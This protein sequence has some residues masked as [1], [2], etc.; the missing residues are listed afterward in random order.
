MSPGSSIGDE[1][2]AVAASP[3]ASSCIVSG[4]FPVEMLGNAADE[5]ATPDNFALCARKI[6]Q[7]HIRA[8]V[9]KCPKCGSNPAGYLRGKLPYP[10][11]R[12]CIKQA[13][14]AA[15]AATANRFGLIIII[16]VPMTAVAPVPVSVRI[17]VVII[18]AIV[19]WIIVMLII[20]PVVYRIRVT[21]SG[22]DRYTKVLVRLC[23]LR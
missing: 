1:E 7:R 14:V 15:E 18:L 16:V 19:V 20:A 21:I 9:I 10:H 13:F 17:I 5:R 11:S 3:R 8:I 12:S 22:S 23:F 4:A 2:R 6:T